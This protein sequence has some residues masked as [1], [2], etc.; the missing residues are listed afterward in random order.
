MLFVATLWPRHR[1]L[2]AWVIA[3]AFAFWKT[4]YAQPLIDSFNEV[5]PLQVGRT[6]DLGDLAALPMIPLAAWAAPRLK[7]WPLPRA[8]QVCL[9]VI[10][11]IAFT[12]TSQGYV[13]TRATADFPPSTVVDEEVLQTFIDDVAR[14]H[15]MSCPICDPLRAGRVYG[16][17]SYI[18]E[19][20][21]NFAPDRRVLFFAA[22]GSLNRAGKRDL[23]ELE[24]DLRA[25]LI[26]RFPGVTFSESTNE[27]DSALEVTTLTV[28]IAADAPPSVERVEGTRRALSS[29]VEEVVRAHGLTADRNGYYAG[30][31]RS[32]NERDVVLVPNY[33]GNDLF[34]VWVRYNNE[35]YEPLYRAVATDLAGRLRTQ[36]GPENVTYEVGR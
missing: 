14:Q 7:P 6:V 21:V 26:E 20:T 9:A 24:A 32:Q 28:R 13:R 27:Y 30:A 11:P 33:T 12:A 8:L 25:G 3:A 2:A 5:L 19:L 34:T 15:G 31:R 23:A 4:R 10:A 18:K 16:D 36:F 17:G 22:Q 35:A 29:I 1:R